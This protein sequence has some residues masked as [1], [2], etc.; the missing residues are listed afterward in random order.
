MLL[1]ALFFLMI[2][3]PPRST[4]FPYTTLFRSLNGVT[5]TRATGDAKVGDSA[6]AS[7]NWED[8]NIQISPLT[9]FNEI[10]AT[11]TLTGQ[12]RN[13]NRPN[14]R[15]AEIHNDVHCITNTEP[16]PGNTPPRDPP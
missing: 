6:N 3:R 15:N 12:D 11:H 4:L 13:N 5:L 2:R 7:K 8:A 16:N 14:Y 9:A 1:T 10:G